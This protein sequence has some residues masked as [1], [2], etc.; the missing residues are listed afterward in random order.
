MS[1]TSTDS[2]GKL[3]LDSSLSNIHVHIHHYEQRSQNARHGVHIGC[4]VLVVAI[5]DIA[6]KA[7]L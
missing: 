4:N 5:S 1:L 7:N 2:L 6:N 3:E